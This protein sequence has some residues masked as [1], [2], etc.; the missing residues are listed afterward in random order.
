MSSLADILA[1]FVNPSHP[2]YK[3]VLTVDSYRGD[4]TE[5]GD[6][7]LKA[8]LGEKAYASL[9]YDTIACDGRILVIVPRS[10]L[11]GAKPAPF[12]LHTLTA[13]HHWA[14]SQV[15]ERSPEVVHAS[16]ATIQRV[17]VEVAQK[18]H[19]LPCIEFVEVR[20]VHF[21]EHGNGKT[22]KKRK[23]APQD[24]VYF[25]FEGGYGVVA[26]ASEEGDAK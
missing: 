7:R 21:W 15:D 19:A 3:D 26:A 8:M 17:P 16:S 18:L 25:R 6:R 1:K 4:C 20:Y 14:L 10:R 12:G 2:V 22:K 9:H 11:E 13:A 24:V 5:T 23:P